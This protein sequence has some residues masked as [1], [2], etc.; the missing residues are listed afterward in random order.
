M[1]E[2]PKR[3]LSAYNL[4]F[5]D[6]RAKMNEELAYSEEHGGEEKGNFQRDFHAV[7]VGRSGR[8]CQKMHA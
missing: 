8:H 5:K 7:K 3:P 4:Y 2:K 6:Q 1:K